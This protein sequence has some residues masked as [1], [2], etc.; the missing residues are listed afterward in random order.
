MST[1]DPSA[2]HA[3]PKS[4]LTPKMCPDIKSGPLLLRLYG[5]IIKSITSSPLPCS[6]ISVLAPA[7]P[8]YV[9]KWSSGSGLAPTCVEVIT[10]SLLS[11]SYWERDHNSESEKLPTLWP[12]WWIAIQLHIHTGPQPSISPPPTNTGAETTYSER[13]YARSF[14]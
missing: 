11:H 12:A 8:A 4:R 1:C 10:V 6:C 2:V 7:G 9:M 14:V 13:T 3:G 5:R